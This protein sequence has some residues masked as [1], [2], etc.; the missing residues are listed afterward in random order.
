M[1]SDSPALAAF[2]SRPSAVGA[3]LLSS[4]RVTLGAAGTPARAAGQQKYM[5]SALPFHGC[6]SPTLKPLVAAALATAVPQLK[7]ALEWRD[8]VAHLWTHATHR[9][10]KYAALA[11]ARY[12]KD[13]RVN[14]WR[15][16]PTVALPLVAHLVSTG[17]WWDY[18]DELSS[19]HL[20]DL[21]RAHPVVVA[22]ELE[23]WAL[24]D[25]LW[26]RRSA[27]CAQL[28]S[29]GPHMDWALLQ[30]LMAPTEHSGCAR[31]SDGL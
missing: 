20:G 7:D 29:K 10:E 18:V 23:K 9:E 26:L 8:A 1:N 4:L 17:A 31:P 30:R 24:G 5:K 19:N 27:I 28:S 15:I 13:A 22:Q 3:V 6:D 12:A 11:L 16:D 21:L 14:L 2:V 25:N